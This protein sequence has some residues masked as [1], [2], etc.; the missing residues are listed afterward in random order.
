MSPT[1]QPL[2]NCDRC[3]I[4]KK[5]HQKGGEIC[6]DN[7]RTCCFACLDDCC[8]IR[9]IYLKLINK[10]GCTEGDEV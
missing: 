10:Y 9:A 7:D 2:R 1:F 5:E 8:P 3:Q 6:C 4:V